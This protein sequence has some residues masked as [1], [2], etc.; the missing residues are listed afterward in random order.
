MRLKTKVGLGLM[1]LGATTITSTS[2]MAKQFAPKTEEIRVEAIQELTNKIAFTG[3]GIF[4]LGAGILISK[5]K[6]SAV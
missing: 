3:A 1:V 4:G 6:K 2:F 5:R